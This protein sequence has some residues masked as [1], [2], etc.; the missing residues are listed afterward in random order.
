MKRIFNT[1]SFYA[2]LG[3]VAIVLVWIFFAPVQIGGQAYYVIINGNSMEPNFH[4]GDLVVLKT[5]PVYSVGDMV[6]YKYPRLGNVFHR[7]VGI[8]DTGSYLMQGDHNAWTDSYHPQKNE[9]IGKYWFA[10]KGIGNFVSKIKSPW[11]IALLAG[12]LGIILGLTM[13][14]KS[15][16]IKYQNQAGTKSKMNNVGKKI[17]NSRDSYY[18]IIYAMGIIAIVLGIFAFTRPLF[19]L[20]EQKIPYTH[21]GAFTYT[22]S[23]SQSVYDTKNINT[24][25][26]VFMALT[27]NVDYDFSYALI[28]PDAFSGGGTYQMQAVLKGSNGWKRTFELTPVTNFDG[29]KFQSKSTLNICSL[30][31]LITGTEILA[32]IQHQQYTVSI[33]PNVKIAGSFGSYDVNSSFN[34]SL[35]FFIDSQQMYLPEPAVN[36]ASPLLPKATENIVTSSYVRNTLPIFSLELPVSIARY[37]ALILLALALLGLL[38][39]FIIF[40]NASKDDELLKAKMLM[41]PAVVETQMSPVSGHERIV[42]L[43]KFEDLAQLAERTGSTVFFHQQAVYVDYLI[44]DNDLVYRFR[45][46]RPMLTAGAEAELHNEI[47]KAI[48]KNE[49]T[50]YYQPI[51]TLQ[52]GKIAQVEAFLRWNHPKRGLL[53]AGEF[54]PQAENS[55][56]ITLIDNWV[57]QTACSQLRNWHETGFGPIRLSINISAQQLRDESLS[58]S[59]QDA[60]LENQIEPGWLSVEIFMDQVIFDAAVMNNLKALKKL[61]VIITVKSVDQDAVDKL[62]KLEMVDQ[63]KIGQT[64]VG[65]VLKNNEVGQATQRIIDQAHKSKVGVIAAGVETN[66][67][68][69]FFKINACDEIQGYLISQP[70]AID[71]MNRMLEKAQKS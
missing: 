11:I 32:D 49:L 56:A 70:L 63:L 69:G 38:I 57:L 16:L 13:V 25:D 60:L 46:V 55:G 50:L 44:K 40:N 24:G 9:I 36:E 58:R 15:N 42:D 47:L 18:W 22:G 34:P 48:K 66:E 61:G 45:Q 59:V 35:M 52:T 31:D 27:C 26:P 1:K 28:T 67:Q 17:A 19:K 21:E 3:F 14:Q 6:A 23:A 10:I 37:I 2:A 12:I 7:I 65:Q 41:G 30:R 71:E 8:D 68:L 62:H 5:S 51:L 20:D 64:I 39:P 53:A 43:A 29:N 54:L 4:R 33:Y